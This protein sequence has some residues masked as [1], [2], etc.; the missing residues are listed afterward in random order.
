[1]KIES[2]QLDEVAKAEV[3]ELLDHPLVRR[4]M[5]LAKGV[6]DEKAYE[7]FIAE[8]MVIKGERFL[9]YRLVK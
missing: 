9:S 1:M 7:A 2:K 6:F 8:K 3:M 4:H 5:P